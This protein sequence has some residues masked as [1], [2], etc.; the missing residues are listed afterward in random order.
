MAD[1]QH[2]PGP[3]HLVRRARARDLAALAAVQDASTALLAAHVGDVGGTPLGPPAPPGRAR[4]EQP[5][6]L[7]VAAAGAGGEGAVVGFAHVLVL[8]PADPRAHLEQLSVDPAHGRG[9]IGT[10]LVL[11]ALGESAR[12]GLPTLSLCTF[13]DV[14][15]N[16]PLYA[17]LG[18]AE[19][20]PLR[21]YQ[22][23]LRHR[24]RRAGLDR[25]GER[26]V[27]ERRTR[28]RDPGCEARHPS[29]WGPRPR[30]SMRA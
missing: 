1:T 13:R 16:A 2:E 28:A 17:R 22:R 6:F 30:D 9:G 27:L 10:A 4:T 8:D 15:F 20:S 14:A 29:R 11:A 23:D 18:F 3:A 12:D 24:E 25:L 5:G 19:P 26:V 7:L 21:H